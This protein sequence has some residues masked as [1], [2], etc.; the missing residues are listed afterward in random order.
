[1]SMLALAESLDRIGDDIAE[2]V[3]ERARSELIKPP[4][5]AQL[6]EIAREIRKEID[7]REHPAL[8]ASEFRE[9]IPM[10]DDIRAKVRAMVDPDR[11]RKEAEADIAAQDAEWQ[12]RKAAAMA[13]VRLRGVCDGV[14][15][16]AVQVD[17]KWVCPGCG[18]PVSE[19]C[20]PRSKA[21]KA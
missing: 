1:M 10:P 4:S 12:R 11:K 20:R 17:G 7:E 6:Y 13:A 5:V 3:A 8:A 15:Q 18:E 19:G 9:N 21:A 14:G 16:K 2:A